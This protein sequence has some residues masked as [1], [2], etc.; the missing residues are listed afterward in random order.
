MS[1]SEPKLLSTLEAIEFLA[2]E[3]AVKIVSNTSLRHKHSRPLPWCLEEADLLVVVCG[4]KSI[5]S[6]DR[7]SLSLSERDEE[8]IRQASLAKPTV[9]PGRKGFR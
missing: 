2:Q 9:A 3:R 7:E 6:R 4:A 5:E 1:G 8:L